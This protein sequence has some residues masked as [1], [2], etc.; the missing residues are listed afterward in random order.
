VYAADSPS[1]QLIVEK[2]SPIHAAPDLVGKT[3]AVDNLTSFTQFATLEWL[4]KNG[5]DP[6]LV[7]FVELP[8]PALSW[9]FTN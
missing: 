1:S 7:K 4:Q 9:T 6:S 2:T 5:I 3:V 8:Y